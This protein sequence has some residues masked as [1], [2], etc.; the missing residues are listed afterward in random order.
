[1]NTITISKENSVSQADRSKR[2]VKYEAWV[3]KAAKQPMVLETVDLGPLGNEDVEIAVEHCGLCHS[4]VSV[5][6][7]EWG[8]SQYPA[9][10]GPLIVQDRKIG[11]TQAAV[12]DSYFNILGSKRSEI[13]CFEH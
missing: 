2:T 5:L 11:V 10:L 13:N 7:N 12:F 4:D 3:A 1:M 9:I 8:I 6:N